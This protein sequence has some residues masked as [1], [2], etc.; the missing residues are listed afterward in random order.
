MLLSEAILLG[1]MVTRPSSLYSENNGEC[2]CALGGAAVAVGE[3]ANMALSVIYERWIWARK[4]TAIHPLLGH[5]LSVVSIVEDLN[6]YHTLDDDFNF[7]FR[8]TL[9]SGQRWTRPRIAEWVAEQERRLGI[10]RPLALPAPHETTL[11]S[12]R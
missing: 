11:V 1:S 10:T 5:K 9:E 8:K 7:V 12:K 6:G 2:A 3:P 4:E